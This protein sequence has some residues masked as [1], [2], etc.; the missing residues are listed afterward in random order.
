MIHIRRIACSLL[1]AL[2]VSGAASAQDGTGYWDNWNLEGSNT[3]RHERYDTDGNPLASPYP[4]SGGQSYDEFSLNASRQFSPYERF[5]ASIFGLGNDSD[6]RGVD[7]GF[8]PERINLFYENGENDVPFRVEAG[9]YYAGIS[10]RVLQRTLKGASLELQPFGDATRKHSVLFFSGTNQPT[11]R[12][13]D[14]DNDYYNGGSWLIEDRDFGRVSF[15]AVHAYQDEPNGALLGTD[16]SQML[17]SVAT[18]TPFDLSGQRLVLESELAFFDG[19]YALLEDQNDVGA[20]AQMTGQ[21]GTMPLDY[22]LRF[23]RYGTHYRPNGGIVTPD[24]RSYEAHAGWRFTAGPYLRGRLQRYEDSFDSTNELT[25][26]VIGTNLAGPMLTDWVSG[27]NGNIDLFQQEMDDRIGSIDRDSDTFNAS[28]TLPVYR[29]YTGQL[30]LFLQD[31]DDD[32]AAD[33]DTTVK[34][35]GVG[36]IV[37]LAF[38]E[39][40]GS[41]VPGFALR[42][43]DF[44]P[45][46]ESV[47]VNPTVNVTLAN[48]VHRISANYNL[49]NQNRISGSSF[50]TATQTAG[51]DYAFMFGNHEI[52]LNAAYFDRDVDAALDTDAYR[53]GAYWTVRFS[54]PAYGA[55]EGTDYAGFTDGEAPSARFTKLGLLTDISPGDLRSRA[56]ALL[57]EQGFGEPS[58]QPGADVYEAALLDDVIERQ[59]VAVTHTQGKVKTAALLIDVMDTG[60]PRS[61]EQL[62]QRVKERLVRKFGA[63]SSSYEQ[64]DFGTDVVADLANDRVIRAVEWETPSG[65]LRYGI[66]R[67]LDGQIRLELQHSRHFASPR[68][69]LWSVD[70]Q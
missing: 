30:S 60:S 38:D 27:L 59:R 9:D 41:I 17:Y 18:E 49:L 64:G 26:D 70:V 51:L 19:D 8:V 15:N 32:T 3:L 11:Y 55:G 28:F 35:V 37:P 22:R 1:I 48:D 61:V 25:T 2:S 10:Y 54:Q 13:F 62:Y 46:T 14:A 39:F 20:F 67:R 24:R 36:V 50:D 23:E 34:Q 42:E 31:T 53:L 69:T 65:V 5:R 29:E 47:E 33:A 56:T 44:E 45:A 43:V 12:S 21:D 63:P 6:Y 66:P 58:K 68:Q 40:T 4:F 16:N 52:G 7:N 57:A